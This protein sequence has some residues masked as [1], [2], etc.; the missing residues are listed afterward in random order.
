MYF[1]FYCHPS[2][3]RTDL[4]HTS[5]KCLL[6]CISH[7]F[8]CGSVWRSE[9]CGRVSLLPSQ[10]GRHVPYVCGLWA[11][12]HNGL[13]VQPSLSLLVHLPLHLHGAQSLHRPYHGRLRDHQG[14]INFMKGFDRY[15]V[16]SFWDF[17]WL[18]L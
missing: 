14:T 2:V 8:I 12:E 5:S 7:L 6:P 11:K 16:T 1:F 18:S 13:A 10:R 17:A 9:S 4:M 3:F 15:C